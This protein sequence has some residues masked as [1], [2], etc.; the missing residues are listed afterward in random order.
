MR[1]LA[2]P[3]MLLVLVGGIGIHRLTSSPESP[4]RKFLDL[5]LA[6]ADAER[7]GTCY[8]LSTVIVA[9]LIFSDAVTE[10]TP[11][12]DDAWTLSLQVLM[13]GSGGPEHLFH[14][15]TFREDGEQVRLTHVESSEEM[16]NAVN[17]NLDALLSAPIGRRS[18]RVDRCL[19]AGAARYR[20]GR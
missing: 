11:A 3:A 6:G 7:T 19:E 8:S 13:Q 10:W 4:P 12:G 14:R 18:T 15:Y 5:E 1:A 20:P 17:D 16:G 2:G 9:N